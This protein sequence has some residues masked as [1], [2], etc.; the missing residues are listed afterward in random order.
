MSDRV[1]LVDFE[2][3]QA[4]DLSKVPNDVRVLFVLGAKQTKLPTELSIQAHELGERFTY[5]PIKGQQP[6]AVD[7]CIAFYLGEYL[8]RNPHAEC[9]ILSKDKK[10]FDPLVKHLVDERGFKARR[11]NAQKDA[12]P[13]AANPAKK[14]AAAVTAA[15]STPSNDYARLL[16]LLKKEKILPIKRK[17]LDGKVKSWFPNLEPEARL[18][19][20]ERLFAAGIAQEREKR[21]SIKI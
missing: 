3:V 17:G 19:L 8:S 9:V 13:V 1:L 20:I 4:V 5:V 18:D 6:N 10:G 7:F 14:E 12:F 21:V 2:N 16:T 15:A 11:V